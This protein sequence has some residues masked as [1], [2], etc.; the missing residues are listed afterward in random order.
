MPSSKV[1]PKKS[2]EK[3]SNG[4]GPKKLDCLRLRQ[5]M[6][7]KKLTIYTLADVAGLYYTQTAKIL[8]GKNKHPHAKTLKKLCKALGVSEKV[9]VKV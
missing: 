5:A 4:N 1:P 8:S 9:V 3:K 6:K 7:T 2:A